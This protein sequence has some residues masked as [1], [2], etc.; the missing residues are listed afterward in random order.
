MKL[1]VGLGNPGKQYEQ[2]RHN[3]GFMAVDALAIK[4]G[5]EWRTNKRGQALIAK[6]NDFVLAKP[7]T[8][9]N[10]SGHA[11]AALLKFYNFTLNP[12]DTAES[13]QLIILHD[14]LDVDMGKNKIA[15]GSRA[16]GHNGVQSIIDQ[17][18]T[19]NFTRYRLGIRQTPPALGSVEQFVLQK[20]TQAELKIVAE[21]ISTTVKELTE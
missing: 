7:Q 19:N 1:V 8:F 6:T 14:D 2:T 21:V 11:V 17:I 3:Y 20:F 18:G 9:M 16:A 13:C 4:L 10:L 5:A 12:K 15:F